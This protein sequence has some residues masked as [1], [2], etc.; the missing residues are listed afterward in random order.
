[1]PT[2]RELLAV[3]GTA[4]AAALAGCSGGESTD[5]TD[6]TGEP[7]PTAAPSS[8]TNGESPYTGVY[9]DIVASVVLIRN[10]NGSQGTGFVFDDGMVVTNAHVVGSA[11]RVELT[12]SEDDSRVAEVLGRDSL[13]D[14]A[15]IEAADR[16]DYAA[17][18]PLSGGEPTIGTE[19]AVVGSPFGLRNSLTTGVVSATNR[20]IPNRK[21]NFLLPNAIQ[22]DAA[23][24]PGNSGGPLVDL[25]GNVL[26]VIN[27]GRGDNIAFAISP[28]LVDRVVP[29]LAEEGEYVHPHLGAEVRRVTDTIA[30]A[31][32]LDEPRGALV[33]AVESGSPAEG[34]LQANDE[35]RRVDGYPI[36]AGGDIVLSIDGGATGTRQA[37]YEQLFLNTSPGDTV[38][39]EFVR[40]G[41]RREAEV[42]LAGREGG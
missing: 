20:L 7:D 3:T 15:A 12:Y 10:P 16:P 25:A 11:D 38:T 2:R 13:S 40:D 5:T 24:N 31:R 42:T 30:R 27:S 28:P 18:L 36:P 23:V 37:Y 21:S 6:P 32:G 17:P 22:T 4:L 19:V 39:V 14:L 41:E 8:G 26:G 9:R 29:T 33:T 1:M 35:T 34:V